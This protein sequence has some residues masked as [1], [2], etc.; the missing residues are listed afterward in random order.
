[1]LTVLATAVAAA[2]IGGAVLRMRYRHRY[3]E[4][5]RSCLAPNRSRGRNVFCQNA[6]PRGGYCSIHHAQHSRDNR[7]IDAA[8]VLA[9]VIIAASI[10]LQTR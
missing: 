4:P 1:M 10:W 5:N 2:I 8:G 6:T 3:R 7:A 9:A